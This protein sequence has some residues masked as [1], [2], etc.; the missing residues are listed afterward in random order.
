MRWYLTSGVN[1]LSLHPCFGSDQL[2]VMIYSSKSTPEPSGR[3]KVK[4][5]HCHIALSSIA[6]KKL[7]CK[8]ITLY[9]CILSA[10]LSCTVHVH[11]KSFLSQCSICKKV[12]VKSSHSP[13]SQQQHMYKAQ[14]HYH[15]SIGSITSSASSSSGTLPPLSLLIIIF[16]LVN[17]SRLTC[18]WC[19][20]WFYT[21]AEN[22][23]LRHPISSGRWPSE[24][25]INLYFLRIDRPK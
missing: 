3:F 10:H 6:T 5:C 12:S 19:V 22:T 15:R 21:R 17:S 23:V 18:G 7:L 14:M 11:F 2:A 8:L 9:T 24:R 20:V 25:T 1:C 16:R 4:L 13:K